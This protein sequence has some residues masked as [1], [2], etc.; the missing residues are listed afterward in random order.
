MGE[1]AGDEGGQRKD[2][3]IVKYEGGRQLHRKLFAKGV[4]QIHSPQGVQASL[5]Q[6]LVGGNLPNVKVRT[7]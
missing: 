2:G 4:A 6:R 3:G 7:E 5:H 1:E